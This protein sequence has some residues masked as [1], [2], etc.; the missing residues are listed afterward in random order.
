MEYYKSTL[1][2]ILN[3]LKK[4]KK[5]VF[6]CYCNELFNKKDIVYKENDKYCPYCYHNGIIIVKE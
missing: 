3:I 2:E 4:M 1:V 5:Q 6:C